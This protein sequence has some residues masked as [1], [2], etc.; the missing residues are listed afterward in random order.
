M[1]VSQFI[2]RVNRYW[3][4]I[5]ILPLIGTF[6]GVTSITN[7]TNY[8][9]SITIGATLNNQDY[10]FSG[11]EN[12]DRHLNTLSEYLVNRFK[13]VDTQQKIID[14]TNNSSSRI[15][16]KKPFYEI[17]DQKAGFVNIS[18]IV[19]SQ[20][21][22]KTFNDAI[23]TTYTNLINLEKNQNELTNYKITPAATFSE[24]ISEYNTPIQIQALPSII[25]FL[26]ALLIVTILPMKKTN[27]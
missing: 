21:E 20:I 1:T 3:Y 22:A 9:A 26:L 11:N 13:A 6:F 18:T 7:R 4:V 10:V 12:F 19:G 24:S 5:L 8:R 2:H 14:L 25:G 23:K 16:P 27:D 17:V 15:D